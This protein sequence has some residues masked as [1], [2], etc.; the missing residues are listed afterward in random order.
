MIE[1]VTKGYEKS[2]GG[3]GVGWTASLSGKTLKMTL[4]F[5]NPILMEVPA[6]VTVTVDKQIVKVSGPTA[7]WWAVCGGHAGEAQSEPYNGR[8]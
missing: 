6:G 1:G 3:G 4:G 7:G 5:A 2:L 8:V